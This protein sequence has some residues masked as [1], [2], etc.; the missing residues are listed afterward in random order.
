MLLEGHGL[1]TFRPP[2]HGRQVRRQ[3]A[4]ESEA[5]ALSKGARVRPRRSFCWNIHMSPPGNCARHFGSPLSASAG[6]ATMLILIPGM[7]VGG[8]SYAAGALP[9]CAPGV[10]NHPVGVVPSASVAIPAGW[11]L[12]DDGTI[13]CLTCHREAPAHSGRS[14]PRLRGLG[15]PAAGGVEFCAR[16]HGQGEEHN[17]KSVHW[18]ALGVAH[19]PG[20]GA[21]THAVNGSLDAGTRQCLSCHD[22]VNATE[23]KNMTPGTSSRGYSGDS[24]RNHPVGVPYHD[25]SR[26]KDLSPLRPA[27]LLPREVTLPDGKVGCTSCHNLYAGTRYLLTVSIQGS[28]LCLTCHDM[29]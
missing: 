25:Q 13:T 26:P 14:V 3:L 27:S 21:E 20:E 7:P 15:S 11:P 6:L 9:A 17:A 16:C 10:T 22:G 24:R 1:G 4:D 12:D 2:A 5:A 28:E 19:V 29:R 23:S 18:L 8:S